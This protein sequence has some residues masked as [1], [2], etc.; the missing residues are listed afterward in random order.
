MRALSQ[1]QRRRAALARLAVSAALPLWILDEPF[2]ALDAVAVELV[3][4]LAGQHLAAG[5]M[6]VITSH[7][8]LGL[9]TASQAAIRLGP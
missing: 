3:R 7:Q 1:G 5:G 9:A 8:D 2:A 6:L 4:S